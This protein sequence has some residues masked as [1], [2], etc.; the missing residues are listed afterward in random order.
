MRWPRVRLTVRRIM[1]AVAVVAADLSLIRGAEALTASG[2]F[3]F[4]IMPA[5]ILVPSL[6]LL[7]VAAVSVGMGL[8]KRGQAPPFSTGYLLLGGLASF[9][10][11][12]TLATQMY[13][14]FT[15]TVRD[16]DPIPDDPLLKGVLGDVLEIA[17][18]A[19]PQVIPALIG[20]G[21]AARFG[22]TIVLR[23]RATA[24]GDA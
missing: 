24:T 6:S 4:V 14:L 2:S 15:V 19:L 1:V 8:A 16:P 3:L 21:L 5:Y 20:G 10:V 18:F 13:W 17:I 12:L 9:G 11:C 23:G 22:L 7:A